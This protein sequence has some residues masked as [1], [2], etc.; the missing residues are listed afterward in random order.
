M[1]YDVFGQPAGDTNGTVGDGGVFSTV[2]DLY[3]WDR[4]L[5]GSSLVRA[6]TLDAAFAPPILPDG[7]STYGFGWNVRVD[8]G[9]QVLWHTGSTGGYRSYIE[10]RPLEQLLIVMLTNQATRGVAIA[11]ATVHILRGELPRC[12]P[13]AL[14]LLHGGSWSMAST[15]HASYGSLRRRLRRTSTSASPS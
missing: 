3:E 4:A 12:P 15:R 7:P 6:S 8:H 2:D 1:A 9:T 11:S 5:A 10:R 13:V 14:L